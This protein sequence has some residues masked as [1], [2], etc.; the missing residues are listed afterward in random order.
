MAFLRRVY[1][2]CT[3]PGLLPASG[4]SWHNAMS[5]HNPAHGHESVTRKQR[6]IFKVRWAIARAT[7]AWPHTTTLYILCLIN[8]QCRNNKGPRSAFISLPGHMGKQ[9]E[10]RLRE[11]SRAPAA[12]WWAQGLS[13]LF[14]PPFF[15]KKCIQFL[16]ALGKYLKTLISPRDT[17]YTIDSG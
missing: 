12:R 14:L 13:L 7:Q 5:T 8:S 17:L 6:A 15:F 3:Q 10:E 16:C 1:T 11:L 4:I 9:T 2:V